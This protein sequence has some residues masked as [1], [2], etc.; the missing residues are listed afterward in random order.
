MGQKPSVPQSGTTI[1]VIGAGLPRTGTASFSKAL[2]ILL[3]GPVFHCGTQATL[4]PPAQIK[5]WMSILKTWLAIKEEDNDSSKKDDIAKSQSQ[6][7]VLSLLHRQLDGYAAI[8]DS[9]GSQFIPELMLLYPHAKVICT[10]RD[11]GRWE[12]S[13]NV[14]MHYTMFWFLRAVLFPLPGMRHFIPY[15]HLLAAQ[16]NRLYGEALPTGLTYQRHLAWLRE[17]VPE[18]RLVFFDARDGWE[19]LCE[20]L[21]LEVP[22]G[23]PF[24]HVNE[25]NGIESIANLHIRR[26][27]TRWA[28]IVVG[29]AVLAWGLK[30]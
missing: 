13:M 8:T 24:P 17:V 4:G 12:K 10:I 29:V 23:I 22:C 30:R 28:L 19:P 25:G 26:G 18:E 5:T 2:E 21:G 1:Q 11:V 20:A 27:L 14:V 7:H 6:S 15:L 16:W 3:K 9:P